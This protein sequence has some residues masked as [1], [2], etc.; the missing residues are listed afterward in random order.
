MLI[1]D[2]GIASFKIYQDMFPIITK[3]LETLDACFENNKNTDYSFLIIDSKNKATDVLS[4]IASGYNNYDANLKIIE[5][6]KARNAI[7]KLQSNLLLNNNF[8][9]CI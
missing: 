1:S 5:Y 2:K 3:V 4:F 9:L 7:S 8:Y 6:N